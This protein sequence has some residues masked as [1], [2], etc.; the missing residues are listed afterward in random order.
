MTSPARNVAAA[1]PLALAHRQLR[2]GL[3]LRAT[4]AVLAAAIAIAAAVVLARAGTVDHRFPAVIEGDSAT[5][6]TSYSGP[7]WAGAI[8]LGALAGLLLVSA[9]TDLWRRRLMAPRR[10]HIGLEQ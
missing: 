6:I 1:A 3:A 8:G 5:V 7:H 4:L 2:S 10:S 9:L